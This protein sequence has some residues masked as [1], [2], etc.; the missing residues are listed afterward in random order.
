ME[1]K[2]KRREAEGKQG[3]EKQGEGKQ[4]EERDALHRSV[5]VWGGG[6]QRSTLRKDRGGKG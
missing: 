6:A 2:W 3:E 5:G 1:A 4:G